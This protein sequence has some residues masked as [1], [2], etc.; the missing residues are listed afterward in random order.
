MK[1]TEPVICRIKEYELPF[2]EKKHREM[3]V[4]CLGDLHI[5]PKSSRKQLSLI[6]EK[7]KGIRPDFII[8][9]GDLIDSPEYLDNPYALKV[10]EEELS[11]FSKTAKTVTTLGNHDIMSS[12]HRQRTEKPVFPEKIVEKWERITRKTGVKLLLDDW[13]EMGNLRVF[14]F[15]QDKKCLEKDE[16]PR[17][18]LGEME[19]KLKKLAKK[20]EL[21]TKPGKINW[22]FSH[23]PI[24]GLVEM[25]ELKGF[26]VFSFGHTHGGCVPIGV[27]KIIDRAKINRGLIGPDKKLFP[28]TQMRGIKILPNRARV[29]VNSGMTG[30]SSVGPKVIQGANFL[31]AAEITV[32]KF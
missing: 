27:D 30:V 25:D 3:K 12:V 1:L 22:F 19:K 31:K 4:V 14:G 15:F 18:N 11:F 28:K 7:I 13:E 20:G 26:E 23:M 29:I 6:E 21:L 17:E 32:V 5:N 10:L 9:Q 24:K 2:L 8:L 16:K